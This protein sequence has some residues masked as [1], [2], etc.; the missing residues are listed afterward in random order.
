MSVSQ[1][2]IVNGCSVARSH[3]WPVREQYHEIQV[4]LSEPDWED[5][6]LSE[7]MEGVRAKSNR[8]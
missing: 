6:S 1:S 7:W 2:V 5:D 3:S 4:T 8:Q